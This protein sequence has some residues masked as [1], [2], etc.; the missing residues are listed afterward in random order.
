V[1]RA[2]AVSPQVE[3]CNVYLAHPAIAPWVEPFIDEFSSFPEREVRRP[4]GPDDAGIELAA[5]R[6]RPA[7]EARLPASAAAEMV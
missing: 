2:Q 1:A 4:G 6:R 3:S 7:Q 5:Q